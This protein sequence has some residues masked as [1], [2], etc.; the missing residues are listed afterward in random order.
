MSNLNYEELIDKFVPNFR[1]FEEVLDAD[2]DI[3]VDIALLL[4]KI[5]DADLLEQIGKY[6]N[7]ELG[8][9]ILKDSEIDKQK[10]D[11]IMKTFKR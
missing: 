9:C 4:K 6:I 1:R 5:Y 8:M 2:S 10:L 7:L 11:E 3:I